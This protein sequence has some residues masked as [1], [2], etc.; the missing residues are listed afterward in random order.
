[1]DYA[2]RHNWRTALHLRLHQLTG[3]A[4]QDFFA[5]VMEKAFGSAYVRVRPYGKLGDKGCDGY[6]SDT[7][8][9][10]QCYGPMQ[11]GPPRVA[12]LIQ[13]MRED[14][15][16]SKSA[17]ASIMNSWL[18]THNM[19]KGVPSESLVEAGALETENPGLAVGF[20]GPDS[21]EK[22]IFGLEEAQIEDLLGPAAA[23]A[24]YSSPD[25]SEMATMLQAVAAGDTSH[26]SEPIKPVP[27]EKL[28]YNKLSDSSAHLIASGM[29]NEPLID[30]YIRSSSDPTLGDR[31]ADSLRKRYT[32]L[33]SEGFD[34]DG[35]YT[36]LLAHVLGEHR[37]T[38]PRPAEQVAAQAIVSYFF[39]SCDIFEDQPLSGEVG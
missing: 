20:F 32:I 24:D 25:L 27:V 26:L 31:I 29:L 3:V 38:H 19:M 36:L 5:D 14:F 6:R 15:A 1:V 23:S 13:K 12:D 10:H 11:Q 18:F 33:K 21:F 9:V 34:P 17:L 4:F 28:S 2:R 7:G 37:V 22:T 30:E 39:H 35:I 16:K 8:A